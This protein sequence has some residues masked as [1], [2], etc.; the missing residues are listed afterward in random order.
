MRVPRVLAAA[1]AGQVP[2]VQGGDRAEDGRLFVMCV[3]GRRDNLKTT[4]ENLYTTLWM[5]GIENKQRAIVSFVLLVCVI[6]D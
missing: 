2:H 3:W 5:K 4:I 1:R 6:S